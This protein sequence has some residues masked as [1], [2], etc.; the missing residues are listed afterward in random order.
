TSRR[1]SRS[2]AS[3]SETLTRRICASTGQPP[4]SRGMSVGA[5]PRLL[6]LRANSTPNGVRTFSLRPTRA[7]SIS[8]PGL[9]MSEPNAKMPT[10][11]SMMDLGFLGLRTHRGP[12]PCGLDRGY[13]PITHRLSC[14]NKKCHLSLVTALGNGGLACITIVTVA[15]PLLF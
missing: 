2:F 15:V 1:H 3:F 6:L 9:L 10:E 12:T 7:F 4:R 5:P 14:D 11:A 13:P 8:A